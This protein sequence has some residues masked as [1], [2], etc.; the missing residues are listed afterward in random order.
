MYPASWGRDAEEARVDGPASR[1][2][3]R[4]GQPSGALPLPPAPVA[5][6][7]GGCRPPVRITGCSVALPGWAGQATGLRPRLASRCPVLAVADGAKSMA[8]IGVQ[9]VKDVLRLVNG[10]GWPAGGSWRPG[11]VT[12]GAVMRA[13]SD[14]A[15]RLALAW[16]GQHRDRRG[17]GA[18]RLR[19]LRSPGR[20]PERNRGHCRQDEGQRKVR[21]HQVLQG[22]PPRLSTAIAAL[23]RCLLGRFVPAL[24]APRPAAG[25]GRLGHARAHGGR[26]A[27]P[28]GRDEPVGRAR[29]SA[30]ARTTSGSRGSSGRSSG[31]RRS[32]R[33]LGALARIRFISSPAAVRAG[34]ERAV[35]AVFGDRPAQTPA[36]R[37]PRRPPHEPSASARPRSPGDPRTPGPPAQRT[38][39]RRRHARPRR[40]PS[41]PDPRWVHRTAAASTRTR[42]RPRPRWCWNGTSAA[43]Y[44]APFDR[45]AP[46]TTKRR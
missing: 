37:T 20:R 5:R 15:L 28:A 21:R 18:R 44:S 6:P 17:S 22:A 9:L 24:A 13:G 36:R 16:T 1:P 33:I 2:A 34:R 3:V 39:G 10:A 45:V 35:P 27:R 43:A 14:S 29:A 26:L 11:H 19:W 4:C 38:P 30:L 41:G 32:R 23:W 8:R 46:R 7:S 40:R 25:G 31:Q 42:H 12:P